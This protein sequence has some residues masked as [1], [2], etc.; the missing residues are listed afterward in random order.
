MVSSILHLGDSVGT[1][2]SSPVTAALI[3]NPLDNGWPLVF[4]CFGCMGVI[5][6]IFWTI[7]VFD[8]PNA[9]P[10]ISKNEHSFIMTSLASCDS[11]HEEMGNKGRS[12]P[13]IAALK[14]LPVWG[15]MAGSTGSTWAFYTLLTLLP[16]YMKTVLHFDT[17]Q[18]HMCI[19]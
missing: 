7:I 14:S 1:V 15:L 6:F 5:W 16:T 11:L 8:T 4:Y 10:R 13:W 18:V 17:S 2:L 3:H 19:M 9:H 12:F